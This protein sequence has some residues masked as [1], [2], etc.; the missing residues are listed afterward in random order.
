MRIGLNLL[1]V[2]PEIG[3][4]WNY[5]GNLVTALGEINRLNT[6]VAFATG[7]PAPSAGDIQNRRSHG[8]NSRCN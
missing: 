4:G 5:I 7:E 8:Q 1:H 6:Y 3:G 2:M